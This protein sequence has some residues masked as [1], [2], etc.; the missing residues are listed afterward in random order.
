[1]G[2]SSR[3]QV[4]GQEKR[5]AIFSC[6]NYPWSFSENERDLSKRRYLGRFCWWSVLLTFVWKMFFL[7]LYSQK[8]FPQ[9]LLFLVLSLL[10]LASLCLLSFVVAVAAG[11]VP[12][13]LFL[14]CAF[15]LWL[16][17][18]SPFCLWYESSFTTMCQSVDFFLLFCC[19]GFAVIPNLENT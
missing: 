16:F 17:L 6:G 8:M 13:L 4:W 14:W 3:Q 19:L 1:M 7:F 12:H 9:G 15:P 5:G 2:T 11:K 10:E 18:R